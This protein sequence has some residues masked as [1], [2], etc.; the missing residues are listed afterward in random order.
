[1]MRGERF[2]GF[3]SVSRKPVRVI[4]TLVRAR[5]ATSPLSSFGRFLERSEEV[6]FGPL[7]CSQPSLRR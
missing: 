6:P 5:T 3:V 4:G 2:M 7:L 1:M